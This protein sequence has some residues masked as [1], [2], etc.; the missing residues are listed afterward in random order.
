MV[1]EHQRGVFHEMLRCRESSYQTLDKRLKWRIE[2]HLEE[3]FRRFQLLG[4]YHTSE[5]LGKAVQIGA[6]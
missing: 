4:I 5:V 3:T 1:L 6:N 2:S